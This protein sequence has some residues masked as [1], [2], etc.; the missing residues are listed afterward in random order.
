MSWHAG[1]KEAFFLFELE[2]FTP[3]VSRAYIWKR[4]RGWTKRGLSGPLN[5]ER[6]RV[7]VRNEERL[8]FPRWSRIMSGLSKSTGPL[9]EKCDTKM[10]LI[11]IER[12]LLK[13]F[14]FM[15]DSYYPLIPNKSCTEIIK[16]KYI[17]R[18]NT[19]EFSGVADMD[20]CCVEMSISK[21]FQIFQSLKKKIKFTIFVSSF[22]EI[23]FSFFIRRIFIFYLVLSFFFFFK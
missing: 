6:R 16:W 5:F 21:I 18:G 1:I 13:I 19:R 3:F 9:H 14:P 22:F 8:S 11:E 17:E 2:F 10:G 12:N 15:N 7:V 23:I 20:I 4:E